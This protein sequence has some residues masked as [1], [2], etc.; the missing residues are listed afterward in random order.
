[1]SLFSNEAIYHLIKDRNTATLDENRL[2]L[3][4]T[5]TEFLS[6]SVL[7]TRCRA[8]CMPETVLVFAVSYSH[9]IGISPLVK[10][11]HS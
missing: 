5:N 11:K 6:H 7:V 1:M 8:T 3:F 10:K 9:I 2:F 4:D